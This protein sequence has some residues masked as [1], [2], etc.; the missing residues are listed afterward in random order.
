MESREG[1]AQEI[2]FSIK[3]TPGVDDPP[4]MVVPLEVVLPPDTV[5]SEAGV[6]LPPTDVVSAGDVLPAGV[7]D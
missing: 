7:V 3:P 2:R 6:V 4:E 5:V 1:G